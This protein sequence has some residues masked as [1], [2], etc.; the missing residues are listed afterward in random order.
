M[1]TKSDYY[2]NK[3]FKNLQKFFCRLIILNNMSKI[4]EIFNRVQQS[5]KEVREIKKIYRDALQNS[6]SYQDVLE[7]IKKLKEKKKHLEEAIKE[8]FASE[9]SKLDTL[10]VDI[11][12]DNMLL[13]DAVLTKL[14]KGENVNLEDEE[15]RTYEPVFTVKFKKS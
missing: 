12:N 11:E 14:V 10:K 15:G 3:Q 13:S 8:D 1:Q 5:K 4:Q 9:F 6:Q 7:E 2:Q